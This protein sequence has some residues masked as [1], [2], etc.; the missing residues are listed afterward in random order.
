MPKIIK[1]KEFKSY[2]ELADL[3]VSRKMIVSDLGK[4]TRKLAQIGYYRLSGFWYPCRKQQQDAAGNLVYDQKTK[5]PIRSEIFQDSVLFEDI[6]KLYL[7]DKKLRFLML[8][9]IERIE[10]YLRG[11]IAHQMG[12]KDPLA[13]KNDR[14]INPKQRTN[15]YDRKRK[16]TRNAWEEWRTR[17]NRSLNSSSEDCILWHTKN[18]KEIPIWVA[19]ETWDFGTMSKYYEILNLKHQVRIANIIGFNDVPC[20]VGWLKNIN[21]L[22]NRCAHHTRIW[23][24]SSRHPYKIDGRVEELVALDLSGEALSRQYGLIAIL[25]FIVKQIGPSSDWLVRV[26]DLIDEKPTIPCCPLT[27]MGFPDNSGF[28]RHLFDLPP[29]S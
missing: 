9:A 23:N 4:A 16:K 26:A 1:V 10:I 19:I 2:E 15:F 7:F 21:T 6:I 17:S 14:Y 11:I 12:Y 5:I 18:K 20:L 25:W 28:P 27:A 3:L 24:R 22:R 8:D 13:Y 29:R